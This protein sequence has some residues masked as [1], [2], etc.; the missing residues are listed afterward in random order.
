MLPPVLKTRLLCAAA[1]GVAAD[2]KAIASG[3]GTESI[4]T[5]L[6]TL[7]AAILPSLEELDGICLQSLIEVEGCEKMV[8][9]LIALKQTDDQYSGIYKKSVEKLYRYSIPV[10]IL[11]NTEPELVCLFYLLHSKFGEC[12]A[13]KLLI[14]IQLGEH[15]RIFEEINAQ[16][17]QALPKLIKS[18]PDFGKSY[19]HFVSCQGRLVS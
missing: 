2:A 11:N 15:R 12:A 13:I 7:F 9:V 8:E 14:E 18:C 3:S 5:P 16:S 1:G 10:I 4:T 6:Q 17:L 19:D